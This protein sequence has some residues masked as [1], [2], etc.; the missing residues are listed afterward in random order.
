MTDLFELSRLGLSAIQERLNASAL[1]AA[2]A[3]TAGYR[4]R[5]A[6]QRPLFASA[7]TQSSGV[8]PEAPPSGPS[9]VVNDLSAGPLR[10]TGRS[11]DVAIL[12]ARP[13][14]VLSDGKSLFI[15]RAGDFRIDG[16]GVLRSASGLR[17]QGDGG[18]IVVPPGRAV[19]DEF[20]RISVGDRT[21]D[22]LQLVVPTD[23]TSLTF[24]ESGVEAVPGSTEPAPDEARLLKPGFLEDSNGNQT[25]EMVALMAN[26]RQYESLVRAAQGYDDMLAHV[27][28]KL[29]DSQG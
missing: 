3:S 15:S 2:N 9:R 20:G 24:S 28:Q 10:Q 29:G 12:S 17:V 18:D 8:A 6:A 1:N 14:F 25:I 19:I 22:K 11:T 5:V 16:N 23:P 21:V 4:R 13:F 7:L 26:V 27:I